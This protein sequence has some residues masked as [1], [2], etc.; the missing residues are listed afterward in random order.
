[1]FD[2]TSLEISASGGLDSSVDQPFTTGHAM[3]EV[4]LGAGKDRAEGKRAREVRDE[5][6]PQ[7]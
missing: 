1:V 3:E 4:L 5:Q 2:D 6:P 7:R